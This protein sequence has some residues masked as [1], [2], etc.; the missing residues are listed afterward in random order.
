MAVFHN[1]ESSEVLCFEC[2]G[3]IQT[4]GFGL[5]T[6]FI[7]RAVEAVAHDLFEKELV[8]AERAFAAACASMKPLER[9]ADGSWS[10]C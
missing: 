10:E 5:P 1:E 8:D 6:G 3:W 7:P 9:A 4:Q 2:V